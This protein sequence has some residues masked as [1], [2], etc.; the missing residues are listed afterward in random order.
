MP[1][2]HTFRKTIT[3]RNWD[4]WIKDER[5]RIV[6]EKSNDLNR[7]RELWGELSMIMLIAESIGRHTHRLYKRL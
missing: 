5:R 7:V 1:R 2:R 6:Y 3:V 4:S